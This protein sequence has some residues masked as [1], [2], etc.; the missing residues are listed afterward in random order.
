MMPVLQLGPLALP[1]KPLLLLVGFYFALWIG[2]KG[3]LALG[4]DED[5]VWTWGIVAAAG[6]LI[7]G[8]ITYVAV[9]YE[10]YA[11]APLSALSPRLGDLQPEMVIVG[12]ILSGYLYLRRRKVD[13]PRFLDSVVPGLI[14]GWAFYA[15]ANFMAGDAYGTIT[16]MPWAIE[17][18]GA[19]RHPT[20]LY[21]LL[22]ALITLVWMLGRPVPRGEGLWAWRLLLAYGTSRLIIEGFRGDSVLLPGGFRLYQIVALGLVLIALWGLSRH[23][24]SEPRMAVESGRQ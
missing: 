7:L 18:W 11:N 20:Q 23:A 16:N 4:L 21:E 2:G 13:I 19:P 3:A 9:H 1:T 6:G 5:L 8:R 15:L 17:L 12:G 22:A 24:P 14:V 10:A